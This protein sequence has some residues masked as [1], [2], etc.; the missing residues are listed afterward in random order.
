MKIGDKVRLKKSSKYW[1]QSNGNIG[2]IT[3]VDNNDKFKY[4]VQWP[5]THAFVYNDEDLELVSSLKLYKL[6]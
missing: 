2:E 1:G 5:H 3:K 4:A 6:L